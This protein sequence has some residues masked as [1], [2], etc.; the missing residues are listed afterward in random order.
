MV[1]Q[2]L[3]CYICG[4]KHGLNAFKVHEQNCQKAWKRREAR[5]PKTKQRPVPPSP[6]ELLSSDYSPEQW[7]QLALQTFQQYTTEPCPK[8][9]RRFPSDRLELHLPSCRGV[10]QPKDGAVLENTIEQLSS[11]ELGFVGAD[12]RSN[13][14]LENDNGSNTDSHSAAW[15]LEVLDNDRNDPE[16]DMDV[17]S[18]SIAS[19]DSIHSDLSA[20]LLAPSNEPLFAICH[21]CGLKFGRVSL[22]KHLKR[23]THAWTTS[24]NK[25][26]PNQRQPVPRGP[27]EL[28]GE[29]S[30]LEQR[31]ASALEIYQ[32]H[33]MKTCLKCN[34][35]FSQDQL[36]RHMPNCR[37]QKKTIAFAEPASPSKQ[38]QERSSSNI[39]VCHLC[40]NKFGQGSFHIHYK[41]CVA[42]WQAQEAQKPE[43]ERIPLP[44]SP[45]E[46][47]GET[48]SQQERNELAQQTH[49]Q[50]TMSSCPTCGRNFARDKLDLHLPRCK[51]KFSRPAPTKSIPK[52]KPRFDPA[53]ESTDVE[54]VQTLLHN[55]KVNGIEAGY[56]GLKTVVCYLCG[57]QYGLPSIAKH[58]PKCEQLWEKEQRT[59]PPTQRRK[60]PSLASS[61]DAEEIYSSLQAY[62][63]AAF[64]VYNRKSL[65]TCMRCSRTFTQDLLHIHAQSCKGGVRS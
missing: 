9:D 22:K 6:S 5:R 60:R 1:N 57:R 20:I 61:T 47:L 14:A 17:G 27:L 63:N 23:C 64:K 65:A 50:S 46:L 55:L 10:R 42:H 29:S 49:F 21:L 25:K 38:Q 32:S 11:P 40:G 62:N 26:P 54:G 44:A 58:M 7:N 3:I 45:L 8:C 37:P 31:N 28:L 52:E 51:P 35:K 16:K 48:S 39:V 19:D 59:L 33:R 41:R 34:R 43:H 2:H 12:D 4:R 30:S 18:E 13:N 56:D 24:E 36:E 53:W 15:S